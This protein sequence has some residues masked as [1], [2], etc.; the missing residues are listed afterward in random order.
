MLTR[1]Q[2]FT[3]KNR[4]VGNERLETASLLAQELSFYFSIPDNFA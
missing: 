4:H 2:T 3:S 1:L